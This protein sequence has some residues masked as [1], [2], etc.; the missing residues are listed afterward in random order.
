MQKKE[1]KG[2]TREKFYVLGSDGADAVRVVTLIRTPVAGGSER[3][4]F[5]E[6]DLVGLGD[7]L[8]SGCSESKVSGG[9]LGEARGSVPRAA[10]RQSP[11]GPPPMM[12]RSEC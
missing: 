4:G 7:G 6:G 2:Q 5:E 11:A 8:G 10:A 12:R 3:G 9:V 1:K